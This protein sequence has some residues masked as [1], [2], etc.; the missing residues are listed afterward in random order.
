MPS[1]VRTR[2]TPLS[3]TLVESFIS[4]PHRELFHLLHEH[5]QAEP[6]R[7][8]VERRFNPRV[9]LPGR[10]SGPGQKRA[11]L[12]FLQHPTMTN[13]TQGERI[14]LRAVKKNKT[15]TATVARP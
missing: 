4:A 2:K 9:W 10:Y 15:K 3:A 12:P 8:I 6:V 13:A 1:E 11:N 14:L 5:D 7:M